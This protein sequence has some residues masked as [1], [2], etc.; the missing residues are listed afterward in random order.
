MLM[1][2]RALRALQVGVCCGHD[3]RLDPAR[4]IVNVDR[5]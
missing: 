3:Q 5:N 1:T 4:G 2:Q